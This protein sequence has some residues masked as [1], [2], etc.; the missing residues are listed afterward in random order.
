MPCGVPD[1]SYC[2]TANLGSAPPGLPED[3]TWLYRATARV[4]DDRF[5]GPTLFIEFE[6][7]RVKARF[8]GNLGGIIDP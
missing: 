2:V 8:L 4:R 1:G 3:G 6:A 7:G 5:F